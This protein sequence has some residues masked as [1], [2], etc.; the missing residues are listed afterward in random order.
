MAKHECL[1]HRV[2]QCLGEAIEQEEEH[3]DES[4]TAV[5]LLEEGD[6][7]VFEFAGHLSHS[8]LGVHILLRT[9]HEATVIEPQADEQSSKS[10]E[11]QCP[12]E[13]YLSAEHHLE[14]SCQR[15]KHAIYEDD[16][17]AIECVAQ[18]DILSLVVVVEFYHIESVGGDVV[19]GTAEGDEEEQAHRGLKPEGG[20]NGERYARKR[21]TYQRLHGEHPPAL[22]LQQVDKRAPQWFDHPRQG[23][24]SR[25]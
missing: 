4:A 23:K 22:G 18:A 20:G 14:Y 25:V 8:A 10:I 1:C 16:G 2:E 24:P 13:A 21:G 3:D 12:G 19:G 9:G 11:Y 7:H 6:E 5:E 17:K 15:H